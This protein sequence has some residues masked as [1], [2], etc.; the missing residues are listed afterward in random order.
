MTEYSIGTGKIS[1]YVLKERLENL[2]KA[3]HGRHWIKKDLS[4]KEFTLLTKI[5]WKVSKVFP[6]IRSFFSASNPQETSLLLNDLK[7]QITQSKDLSLIDAF[8]KAVVGYDRL[9]H[10]S[11]ASIKTEP[12]TSPEPSPTPTEQPSLTP[13]PPATSP[14]P[15]PPVLPP[16]SKPAVLTYALANP[17]EYDPQKTKT[18]SQLFDMKELMTQQYKGHVGMREQGATLST[19]YYFQN[20]RGGGDCFYLGYISG[21]LHHL[22]KQKAHDDP[23]AFQKAIDCLNAYP[24]EKTSEVLLIL[25]DLDTDPSVENLDRNLMD[26][27]KMQD[28]VQALRCIALDGVMT[29]QNDR[30]ELQYDDDAIAANIFGNLELQPLLQSSN[31]K[32][33]YCDNQVK[34]GKNVQTPEIA[35]LH[36]RIAPLSICFSQDHLETSLRG[37]FAPGYE[38]G[39]TI[40]L[41]QRNNH[42]DVLIPK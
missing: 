15:K 39:H 33:A 27:T 17:K 1:E 8:N 22:L 2:A 13:K 40:T 14:P 3:Q 38:E 32:K 6:F 16:L 36:H 28:F 4:V 12:P 20:C 21:W 18:V 23:M 9:T 30:G 24:N 10:Q 35:V 26:V 42:F 5:I 19:K 41:F 37:R 7:I 11:V 29:Q 34:M 25:K 31:I